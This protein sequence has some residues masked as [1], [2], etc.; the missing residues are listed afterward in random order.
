MALL[1]SAHPTVEMHFTASDTNWVNCSAHNGSLFT[2]RRVS[3]EVCTKAVPTLSV[4]D[5]SEQHEEGH[6]TLRNTDRAARFN[7]RVLPNRAVNSKKKIT[8]FA[9]SPAC[10]YEKCVNKMKMSE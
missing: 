2:V 7:E 3:N 5:T 6:C 1:H 8:F 9:T 4:N 10:P